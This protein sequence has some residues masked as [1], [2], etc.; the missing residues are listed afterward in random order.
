LA[1]AIQPLAHC[2]SSWSCGGRFWLLDR[3]GTVT[4]LRVAPQSNQV[5][6]RVN[7][8]VSVHVH[9]LS[10]HGV[11][12]ILPRGRARN[13][14]LTW[15]WATTDPLLPCVP[16]VRDSWPK[17]T[18]SVARYGGQAQLRASEGAAG[19]SVCPVCDCAVCPNPFPVF[20]SEVEDVRRDG[21][22]PLCSFRRAVPAARVYRAVYVTARLALWRM[23]G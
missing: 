6:A 18:R 17:G 22:V 13:V 16:A 7:R 1:P 12:G 14:C 23:A 20:W 15:A 11:H 21:R 4:L 2:E 5:A 3:R 9:R 19:R 8:Y 10:D